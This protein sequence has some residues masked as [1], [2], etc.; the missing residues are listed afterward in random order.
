MGLRA[1]ARSAKTDLLGSPT[2]RL[3][4]A[5]R[6]AERREGDSARPAWP[7]ASE[8]FWAW[9]IYQHTNDRARAQAPNPGATPPVQAD[10]AFLRGTKQAPQA[11]HARHRAQPAE[12][13]ARAVD[14]RRAP[15]R[16]ADQQPRRTR[17]T[18]RGHLPQALARE[19]VRERRATH[20]AAAL[21]HNH[22]PATTPLAIRLPQRASARTPAAIPRR[23]SPEPTN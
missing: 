14:V 10:R 11:L 8:L 4:R 12:G 15:R 22:L 1:S 21:R 7:S 19:P 9:E 5:R 18:R 6:R 3:H 20:R 17:A 13:L 16:P 23:S 2:A